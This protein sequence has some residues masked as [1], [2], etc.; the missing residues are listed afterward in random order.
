[1]A[2]GSSRY[3]AVSP[4][5]TENTV[6]GDLCKIRTTGGSGLLNNRTVINSEEIRGDGQIIVARLG[7][8]APDVEVPM[9]LSFGGAAFANDRNF[10]NFLAAVMGD[11]D[12]GNTTLPEAYW[13]GVLSNTLE[14]GTITS[15][16]TGLILTISGTSKNWITYGVKV[17]DYLTIDG[18][19]NTAFDTTGNL[20]VSVTAG[21]SVLTLTTAVTVSTNYDLTAKPLTI[22]RG[23]LMSG[24]IAFNATAGT[25]A[26]T[27]AGNTWYNLGYREGDV[28]ILTAGGTTPATTTYDGYKFK[29]GSIDSATGKIITIA[30]DSINTLD[31]G[32]VTEAALDIV[33]IYYTITSSAS[34]ITTGVDEGTF[35][36]AENFTDVDVWH[37]VTGCK[38]GS[39]NLSIQPDSIITG[40]FSLQGQY[41]SGITDGGSTAITT[42]FSGTISDTNINDVLDSFIGSLFF[43]TDTATANIPITGFDFTIDR[44]LNRRYK[45]YSKNAD[46]IGVGRANVSGT[47]NSYFNGVDISQFFDTETELE[48]R[49]RAEDLEGN[50][51]LFGF[52]KV[53]L[54]SD[55]RDISEND[56]TQT[57]NFQALG[58]ANATY[59]T[60]YVYRQI[61][62]S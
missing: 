39:T 27:G 51:Y 30:S 16:A 18:G 6:V 5:L 33:A 61:K 44:N 40:S 34:F 47:L 54:T 48:V 43:Q 17:G 46:S 38:V 14:Y 13:K 58:D 19:A 50:S 41:Y 62:V 12:A 57:A 26:L 53:K 1:M 24:G 55:G 35:T 45:L 56:V 10:E 25:I 9:E 8:N 22:D 7:N 29:I 3:I 37:Y 42:Q 36:I 15:D 32:D 23:N 49:I 31:S 2:E 11:T 59:R 20:V 60:M 4:E 28:I 52:P 21:G